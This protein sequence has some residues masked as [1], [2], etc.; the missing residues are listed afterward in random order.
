MRSILVTGGAGY[1]GSQTV[2]HFQDLGWRVVVVDDLSTGHAEFAERA[3]AFHRADIRDREAVTELL[4]SERFDGVV[5]C[6]AKSLVPESVRDPLTYYHT[7]VLG[8]ANL[9]SACLEAPAP[10]PAVVF[11]SSAAVYG[12]GPIQPLTEELAPDPVNPYGFTKLAVERLLRH[13]DAAYG[14]RSVSLR[15][16]NAAGA[17]PQLRVGERHEPETH[18]IPNLIRAALDPGCGPFRIFGTD[19]DTPDGTCVRDYVHVCDVAEAHR[20]A[21]ERLWSGGPSDVLNLGTGVGVSVRE[22]LDGFARVLGREVDAEEAPR[23]AGDPP[24]LTADASRAEAVLHWT[25]RRDLT[26]ILE[27]ALAWERKERGEP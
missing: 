26:A 5:H 23:R 2:L 9:V 18:V 7:N 13:S 3:D 6:A 22:L 17:D 19:Y 4:R 11:S 24:V 8:A 25:P 15:Y 20:L 10:A 16:F 14:L 27:S 1:I 21:L 12:E